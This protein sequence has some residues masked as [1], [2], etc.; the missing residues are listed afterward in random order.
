MADLTAEDG[1]KITLEALTWKGTAYALVGEQ[2]RKGH[3]GDCSGTTCAIYGAAGFNFPY[4]QAANFPA[5]AIREGKFRKVL[6]SET[7]QDGDIL[8]W[9]GHMAIYS[10][11]S[12]LLE[13]PMRTTARV[14]TKTKQPW[15][16]LNDMWTASRPDGPAYRESASVY[17]KAG[18][19]PDAYRYFMP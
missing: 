7:R 14:S 2:S 12:T 19:K 13:A 8:V 5:W 11:F 16:Q 1:K 3:F 15:T 6:E 17:F 18:A 10:T 4:Q 9:D